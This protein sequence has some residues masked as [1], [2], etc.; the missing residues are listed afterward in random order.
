MVEFDRSLAHQWPNDSQGTFIL[1]EVDGGTLTA[2]I[3]AQPEW[4]AVSL[5]S[6]DPSLHAVTLSPS[7]LTADAGCALPHMLCAKHCS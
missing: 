5:G 6:L 1:P 7:N 3:D 2:L 4:G